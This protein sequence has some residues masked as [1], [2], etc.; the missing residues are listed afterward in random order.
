VARPAHHQRDGGAMIVRTGPHAK[1][2]GADN[3]H[4]CHNPTGGPS[5]RD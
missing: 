5:K 3:S 4:V 1:S 2:G